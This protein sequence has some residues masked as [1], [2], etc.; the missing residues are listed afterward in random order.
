MWLTMFPA[1]ALLLLAA[2]FLRV[3]AW[4]PVVLSVAWAGLLAVPRPWSAHLV[5]IGLALGALEWLRTLVMIASVRISAGIPAGR[6]M[7]IL[8]AV[9]VLTLGAIVVFRHP[10]LRRFYRLGAAHAPEV[11]PHS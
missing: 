2:H 10:K 11:G 7:A 4:I 6:L 8:S 5:R 9:V 1:L 3:D